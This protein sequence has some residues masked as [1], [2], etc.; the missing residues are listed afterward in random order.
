MQ[1]INP[2]IN[3]LNQGNKSLLNN[4]QIQQIKSM[5]NTVRAAQS[6]QYAFNMMLTNNPKLQQAMALVK[7]FGGNPE[8]AFYNYA[9]Q[10]GVDPQEVLNTIKSL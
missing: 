4:P 1:S 9:N 6:P 7:Q 2:V 3:Q 10:L 8:T 5:M